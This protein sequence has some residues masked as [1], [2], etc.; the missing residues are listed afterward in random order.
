MD[1]GWPG[2]CMAV[3]Q[4]EHLDMKFKCFFIFCYFSLYYTVCVIK[5]INY[6]R[7]LRINV[8][9]NTKPK[10]CKPQVTGSTLLLSLHCLTLHSFSV[11]AAIWLQTYG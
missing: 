10:F 11:L 4:L 8:S 1:P 7:L 9:E 2:M 3:S 6:I 5:S